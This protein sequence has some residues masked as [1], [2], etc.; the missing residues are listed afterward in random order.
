[1]GAWMKMDR[2]TGRLVHA[3]V[4]ISP[5]TLFVDPTSVPT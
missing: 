3:L 5:G 1:M 2:A 4:D